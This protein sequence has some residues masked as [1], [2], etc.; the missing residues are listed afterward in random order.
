ML[1]L[2]GALVLQLALRLDLHRLL[3]R[4]GIAPRPLEQGV[5]D[6]DVDRGLAFF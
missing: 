3:D 4:N 6:L 5:F 1:L 2:D